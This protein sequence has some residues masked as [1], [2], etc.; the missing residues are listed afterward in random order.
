MAVIK[1]VVYVYKKYVKMKTPNPSPFR[2]FW[3][4]G[5]ECADHLNCHGDRTDMLAIT[6]HDRFIAEDYAALQEFNISTVREGIRWSKVETQPGIYDWSEV[7]NR[8]QVAKE[9][10]IQQVWDICHFGYPDYLSPLHPHFCRRF[11]EICAAFARIWQIQREDPLLVIPINEMSFISWLGGDVRATVPFCHH[12]G[13]QVKYELAKA[14]ISGI[15]A[16]K[17]ILPNAVILSSEPLIHVCAPQ[18]GEVNNRD[19]LGLNECQFQAMDMVTGRI[20]PELGGHPDLVDYMGFN[21]YYDNEWYHGHGR[22]RWEERRPEWKPLSQL[23]MKAYRRYGKP[24]YLSE[25]SHLG[26]GR[27]E[28]ILEIADECNKV[29]SRGGELAGICLYPIIDRPDWDHT[30]RYHNSG[31]WDLQLNESQVPERVLCR[32]Y[33]DDLKEA[34][35]R[36]QEVRRPSYK[37]HVIARRNDEAIPAGE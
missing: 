15:K 4:A 6:G 11:T 22:I 21:F 23:L 28:W 31:L 3:M 33:A 13:F 27:G 14:A 30:D 7:I 26:T 9:Q 1:P 35:M 16:I 5:Y 17:A 8:I 2:S 20:C 24:M 36:L 12:N 18:Q 10:G 29:I 25:T 32:H 34:Q 19:I 37:N